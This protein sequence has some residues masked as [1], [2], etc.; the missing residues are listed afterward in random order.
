MIGLQISDFG[1]SSWKS[2]TRSH[3]KSAGG[4]QGTLS[5]ISPEKWGNPRLPVDEKFDVYSFSILLWEMFA[6]EQAYEGYE[7]KL[8][9]CGLYLFIV[10]PVKCVET[11]STGFNWFA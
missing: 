6:E 5:H 11:V 1:L 2:Y 10:F 7:G 9:M 4:I 3:S 8:T